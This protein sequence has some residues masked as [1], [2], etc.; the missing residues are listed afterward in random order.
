[1]C[2]PDSMS[3]GAWRRVNLV[4]ILTFAAVATASVIQVLRGADTSHGTGQ[5]LYRAFYIL[6]TA[7]ALSRCLLERTEK[8]EA[9]RS[10][11]A[12]PIGRTSPP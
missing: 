3:L 2:N 6:L 10:S 11:E 7:Q 4:L 9:Q 5:A 1:M 8:R 12:S